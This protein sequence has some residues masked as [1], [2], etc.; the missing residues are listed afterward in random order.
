MSLS[1]SKTKMQVEEGDLKERFK[2]KP[3]IY[4]QNVP[5]SVVLVNVNNWLSEKGK[6]KEALM[7]SISN[8][9]KIPTTVRFQSSPGGGIYG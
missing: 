4:S 1:E 7:V 2:N 8:G 5:F 9:V 6:E 3:G